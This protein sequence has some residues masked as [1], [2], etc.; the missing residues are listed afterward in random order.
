MELFNDIEKNLGEWALG[1]LKK[2]L[3]FSLSLLDRDVINFKRKLQLLEI[4]CKQRKTLFEIAATCLGEENVY[5]K[6][7]EGS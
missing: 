1:E 4:L 6:L 7:I 2:E 5:R 3:A